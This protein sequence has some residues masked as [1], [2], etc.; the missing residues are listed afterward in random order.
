ME[1]SRALIESE[2]RRNSNSWSWQLGDGFGVVVEQGRA[3]GVT[4]GP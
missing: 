2:N 4:L 3:S 1:R